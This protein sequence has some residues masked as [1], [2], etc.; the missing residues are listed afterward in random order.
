MQVVVGVITP[1]KAQ[2][3]LIRS[4]FTAVLGDLAKNV[5]VETV[6]SFQ[7]TARLVHSSVYIGQH[8]MHVPRVTPCKARWQAA[9]TLR[10]SRAEGGARQCRHGMQGKGGRLPVTNPSRNGLNK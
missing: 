2:R 5:R 4:T 10:A 9:F 3:N 6:D 8:C 1:Y 7:V